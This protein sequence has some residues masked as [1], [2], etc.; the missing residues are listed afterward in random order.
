M[1]EKESV[2]CTKMFFGRHHIWIARIRSPFARDAVTF[3]FVKNDIFSTLLL[4]FFLTE[5]IFI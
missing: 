5:F 1:N 2:V 3:C 4:V